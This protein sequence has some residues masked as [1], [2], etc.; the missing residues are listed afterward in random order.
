MQKDREN[1]FFATII[2]LRYHASRIGYYAEYLYHHVG[3][4]HYFTLRRIALLNCITK[5]R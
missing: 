4:L 3:R 2:N 1:V 5:L